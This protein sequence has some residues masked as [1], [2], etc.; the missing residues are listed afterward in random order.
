MPYAG[1]SGSGWMHYLAPLYTPPHTPYT[2][3]APAQARVGRA[4]PHRR[5]EARC[6]AA[7]SQEAPRRRLLRRLGLVVAR[8]G[9][10]TSPHH[11]KLAARAWMYDFCERSFFRTNG[12]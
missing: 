7:G 12:A 6:Q 10:L 5:P 1:P 2:P 9:W 11:W 4:H 8:I 3:L